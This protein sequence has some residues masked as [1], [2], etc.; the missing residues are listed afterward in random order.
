MPPGGQAAELTSMQ[1]CHAVIAMVGVIIV[2][3]ASYL[4]GRVSA[5]PSSS[6]N[7]KS[8]NNTSSTN[9]Q[10][11]V[12]SSIYAFLTFMLCITPSPSTTSSKHNSRH[13]EWLSSSKYKLEYG[14]GE[15]WCAGLGLL[16]RFTPKA[17][18]VC[19]RLESPG[20]ETARLS[21]TNEESVSLLNIL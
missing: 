2:T 9:N 14:N 13:Q 8:T 15:W 3:A 19:T 12:I 20:V 17:I 1:R 11:M 10:D 6:N 18:G 16:E 4:M 7:S 5:A 21:S